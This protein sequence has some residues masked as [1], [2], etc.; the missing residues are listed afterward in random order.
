MS[1]T[2]C[3]FQ[4]D[5]V[6]IDDVSPVYVIAEIGV[7]HNGDVSL[8]KKLIRA[9]AAAGAQAAKLQS[10]SA[11]RLAARAAPKAPYQLDTSDSDQSQHALLTSLELDE[12]AHRELF[13]FAK[14]EG[15]TLLSTPFDEESA[16]LLECLGAPAF[17]ISSGDLTHPNLLRHIAAKGKP[18]LVS[19]GMANI[20]EVHAAV[21]AIA[22]AGDVPIALLHCVSVYPA[23]PADANLRAM[24]TLRAAFGLPVGWSDHVTEPIVGWAAVALG[25]RI[26]EKHIT[27][28]KTM[29]GV[30]HR[31]SADPDEFAAYVAG[32]RMLETA[33][34]DGVK[35]IT[36]SETPVAAV[37]RRSLVTVAPIA[38][39]ATIGAGDLAALRP[40]TGL[41]PAQ[42]P[43]VVGRRAARDIPA[44][45][46]LQL[47]MLL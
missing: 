41:A 29:A 3:A 11:D 16:D 23:S 21:A 34:G 18:M 22:E 31:A 24:T 7:N 42:L 43:N 27:L 8:A 35:T 25:A 38:S 19:T 40:G 28:D 15:I 45:T 36:A 2:G 12:A 9:A 10:F 46:V 14:A 13:A 26:L 6:T 1:R 20:A 37:A 44:G 4:I 33:L 5:G 47:D 39:G 32:V 30:D 17:K